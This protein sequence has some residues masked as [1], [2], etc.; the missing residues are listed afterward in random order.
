[1]PD[2]VQQMGL[3]QA[4][5]AVDEQVIVAMVASSLLPPGSCATLWAAAWESRLQV[6]TR[7]VSKVYLRLN[8]EGLGRWL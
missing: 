3:A 5:A 2:R 4:D 1:M 7:N 6:P 8:F